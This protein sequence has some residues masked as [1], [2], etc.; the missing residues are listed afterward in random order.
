MKIL[1]FEASW[2]N[3]CKI[4]TNILHEKGYEFEAI[5]IDENKELAAEYNIMS[6]PTVVILDDNDNEVSRFVGVPQIQQMGVGKND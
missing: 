1:K 3:P 6:I 5:D 4:A 2:C